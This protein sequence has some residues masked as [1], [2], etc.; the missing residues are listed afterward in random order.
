MEEIMITLTCFGKL[1]FFLFKLNLIRSIE[2]SNNLPYS[3]L[4][5]NIKSVTNER[6]PNF[7]VQFVQHLWV[8]NIFGLILSYRT[9]ILIF[10]FIVVSPFLYARDD[11]KIIFLGTYVFDDNI[12]FSVK[13]ENRREQN[14][15][16][17]LDY[18]LQKIEYQENLKTIFAT[19]SS[20]PHP[21]EYDNYY[22]SD[23]VMPNFN[24]I[25]PGQKQ[26]FHII[27]KENRYNLKRNISV[28]R[29]II[30][31][32]QYFISEPP[33]YDFWGTMVSN[34]NY[35]LYS[36]FYRRNAYLLETQGW[37]AQ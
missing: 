30:E 19:L 31:G 12:I 28:M 10:L 37:Q 4:N 8:K 20:E 7:F 36:D 5:S 35:E 32:I 27:I 11:I 16:I 13:I 3:K 24:I 14:I 1:H 25:A 22:L 6:F 26:L 17:L 2:F 33:N 23:F 9:K 34:Y 18:T 15:Y 29:T 21:L